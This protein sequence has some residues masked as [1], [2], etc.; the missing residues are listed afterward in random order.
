M[1]ENAHVS[2]RSSLLP[3]A[4]IVSPVLWLVTC[5]KSQD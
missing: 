1:H 4:L 2:Y 3:A 5:C